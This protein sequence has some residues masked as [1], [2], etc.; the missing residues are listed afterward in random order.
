MAVAQ[1]HLAV[2][3]ACGNR[4]DPVFAAVDEAV[5]GLGGDA[6]GVVVF[7]PAPTDPQEAARQART[8]ARGACVAGMSSDGV[9]SGVGSIA[10][11]CVAVAFGDGF[12]TGIGSA[13]N[14]A[15]DARA[16]G[17]AAA[18][19]ALAAVGAERGHPL[20]LLFVDTTTLDLGDVVAGAYEVAGARIPLAG[21]GA[22]ATVGSDGSP[23][24]LLANGRPL[25]D[26]VVALAV[27][28]REPIAIGHAHG[29]S[30]L[31][32]PAVV[33][34][35]DGRSI[36]RLNGGPAER[37]YLETLGC[38]DMELNDA[39]FERLAVLHP[40]GELELSG[41]LRLR[42]IHGR[43]VDGG[44]FCS[45]RIPENAAVVVVE[46]TPSAVVASTRK[47]ARAAQVALGRPARLALV[48]DGAA[49][50]RIVSDALASPANVAALTA[51]LEGSP[52]VAGLY[53]RGEIG[54]WRGPYGDRNHEIV[55]VAFA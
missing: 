34:R 7:A 46:E 52:A 25:R 9:I 42:H 6:A 31:D 13:E 29:G 54:R 3:S 17:R 55:V 23:P 2:A 51:A 41:D 39:A 36:L 50:R 26:A 18:A 47:A 49:R 10:D 40:L 43:S 48:F 15:A 1:Q 12:E 28:G 8:A 19:E 11:G 5:A 27:V 30:P 53:T 44:L 4:L 24:W 16:A 45:A 37:V 22:N 38:G 14:G 21:G 35:S 33:S 20:L 32:A